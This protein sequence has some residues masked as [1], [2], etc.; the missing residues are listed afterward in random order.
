MCKIAEV[1][2]LH[3]TQ[4]TLH[5]CNRLASPQQGGQDKVESRAAHNWG[6]VTIEAPGWRDMQKP[7]SPD[8]IE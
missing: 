6:P 7:T 4:Y 8:I 5:R 2:A 1:H 3:S